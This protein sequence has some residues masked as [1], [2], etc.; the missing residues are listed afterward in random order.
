ME[1]FFY[2]RNDPAILDSMLWITVC[3]NQIKFDPPLDVIQRTKPFRAGRY[4]KPTNDV[5]PVATSGAGELYPI[6]VQS[7]AIFAEK[8]MANTILREL[9]SLVQLFEVVETDSNDPRFKDFRLVNL[10]RMVDCVDRGRSDVEWWPDEP[11]RIK[12][13]STIVLDESRI[14]PSDLVFRLAGAS[15]VIIASAEGSEALLRAGVPPEYFG[16]EIF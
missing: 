15:D 16:M 1:N 13:V 5:I 3:A 7:N 8:S 9:G 12:S 10:T 2:F 4:L 6:T 14:A 11:N